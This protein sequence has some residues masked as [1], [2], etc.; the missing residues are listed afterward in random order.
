MVMGGFVRGVVAALI[1]AG[2]VAWSAPAMAKCADNVKCGKNQTVVRTETKTCKA[3][4]QRPAI[5]VRRACCENKKGKIRCLP[6]KKCPKKS[7]SSS[8]E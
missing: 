1:V 8:C 3:N 7:P 6:F 4:K 5:V 2:G